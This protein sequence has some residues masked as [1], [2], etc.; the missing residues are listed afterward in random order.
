MIDWKEVLRYEESSPSKLVWSVSRAK[1]VKEGTS[2]GWKCT[3]KDGRKHN[4][5]VSY[6]DKIYCAHRI[7]WELFNGPI[8]EGMVIDHIN[9]DPWDNRLENLRMVTPKANN[10][11]TKKRKDNKTGF[12]GISIKKMGKISYVQAK[13]SNEKKLFRIDKFGEDVAVKMA[14]EWR[15]EKIEELNSNGNSFSERHGT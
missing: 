12:T 6:L 2:A 7:I 1:N 10:Q 15:K 11:N 4:Y 14:I 13:V 8:P 5:Q 3:Q 9:G